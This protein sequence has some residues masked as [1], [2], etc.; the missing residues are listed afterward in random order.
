MHSVLSHPVRSPHG[1]AAYRGNTNGETLLQLARQFRPKVI[2]DA[3][4]GGGTMRDVARDLRRQGRDV[5]YYGFDLR[6]GEGSPDF[7]NALAGP[8]TDK[9]PVPICW[10]YLHLPYWLMIQYSGEVWGDAPH[11]DDLSRVLDYGEFLAKARMAALNMYAGV[12]RGGLY[13]VQ[14]GDYRNPRDKTYYPLGHD[15]LRLLPGSLESVCIKT[16]HNCRS[17]QNSYGNIILIQHE[18]IYHL[19]RTD[20]FFSLL[21]LTLQ[22]SRRLKRL[23]DATWRAVCEMALRHLGGEAELEEVYAY[24]EQQARDK[25][26]NN[27]DWRARVRATMRASFP[28]TARGRYALS[29]APG[30]SAR[31]A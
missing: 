19:S 9:V 26:L 14:I 27:V 2:C 30:A 22:S 3:M 25:T 23:A 4:E 17:D 28:R 16:Q 24:V 29:L 31:A 11:P 13:S 20:A 10:G 18:Y 7:Y 8:I 15:L 21:G 5:T 12:R 1:S 6:H